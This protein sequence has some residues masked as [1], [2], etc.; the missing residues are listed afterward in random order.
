MKEIVPFKVR[1]R[2]DDEKQKESVTTRVEKIEKLKKKVKVM[3]RNY[4]RAR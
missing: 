2:T 1:E 3:Y 4:K